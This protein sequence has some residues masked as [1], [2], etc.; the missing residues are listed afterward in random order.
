MEMFGGATSPESEEKRRLPIVAWSG[1]MATCLLLRPERETRRH[2]GPTTWSPLPRRRTPPSISVNVPSTRRSTPYRS[3]CETALTSPEARS[4]RDPF[5]ASVQFAMAWAT[6]A[7]PTST[8]RFLRADGGG[9]V[10]LSRKK[11]RSGPEPGGRG[12]TARRARPS[13]RRGRKVRIEQVEPYP[14]PPSAKTTGGMLRRTVHAVG[15]LWDVRQ[16]EEL[17][18]DLAG[19]TASGCSRWHLLCGGGL[20]EG[21]GTSKGGW[22]AGAVSAASRP[23]ATGAVGAARVVEG[24]SGRRG[25]RRDKSRPH[26]SDPADENDPGWTVNET[27]STLHLVVG[28]RA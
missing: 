12:R 16:F 1:A 23:V 14:S 21:G 9:D 10:A 25:Q 3:A 20:E 13:P 17:D 22:F 5:A 26:R 28:G 19:G 11:A 6:T 18:D 2:R 7:R 15:S 24:T 27:P 4:A 8:G